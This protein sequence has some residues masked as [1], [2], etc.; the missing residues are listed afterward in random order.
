MCR[1][2]SDDSGPELLFEADRRVVLF[3]FVFVGDLFAMSQPVEFLLFL[4]ARIANPYI[5]V[6][7]DF[8]GMIGR[9][10]PAKD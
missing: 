2:G 10:I 8:G 3:F 4:D 5:N 6:Q 1:A 7:M 9:E